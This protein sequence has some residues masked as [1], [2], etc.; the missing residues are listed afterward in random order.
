MYRFRMFSYHTHTVGYEHI[1]LQSEELSFN[2][3]NESIADIF[4][5]T[6]LGMTHILEHLQDEKILHNYILSSVIHPFNN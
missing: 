2:T 6:P 5:D 4:R 1:N 3:N